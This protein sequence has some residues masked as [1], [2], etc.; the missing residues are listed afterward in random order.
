MIFELL[1][2]VNLC[3][4]FLIFPRVVNALMIFAGLFNAAYRAIP[5]VRK[6][7]RIAITCPLTKPVVQK[8]KQH[9]VVTAYLV[10][11][12]IRRCC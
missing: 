6:V 4:L 11:Q 10:F 1:D 2:V 9:C 5:R 8:A 12:I 3:H 7:R